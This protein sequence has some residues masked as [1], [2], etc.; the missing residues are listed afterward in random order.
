[1]IFM[2]YSRADLSPL[3]NRQT[4]AMGGGSIENAGVDFDRYVPVHNPHAEFLHGG[5]IIRQCVR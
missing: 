5:F 2:T 1:M 3:E 4:G